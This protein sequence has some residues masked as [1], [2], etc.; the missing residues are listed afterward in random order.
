VTPIA[1]PERGLFDVKRVLR[2]AE[3]GAACN[4]D[5]GAGFDLFAYADQ[6][7]EQVRAEL[8]IPAL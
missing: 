5:L 4:V 2:A 7:L 1:K 8:G 6:P 3:R